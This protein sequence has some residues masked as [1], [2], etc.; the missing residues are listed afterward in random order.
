MV[1]ERV[2]AI[3]DGK[4]TPLPGQPVLSSAGSNWE[5]FLLE[6]H[7][8]AAG[9]DEVGWSWHDTHIGVC[10]AGPSVI[11]VAGGAGEGRFLV[12]PGCI[13]IFPSGCDHTNIHH[14]GGGFEFVVV[15]VAMS[16]LERLFHEDGPQMDRRLGPQ[17]Y[18][19]DPNLLALIQ[20]MRAEV[21]DG[22]PGGALYHESLCLALAAYAA[23]RYSVKLPMTRTRRPKLSPPQLRRVLEYID[24]HLDRRMTLAELADVVHVSPRHFCRLFRNTFG[25]T[26]HR[27]VVSLRVERARGLLAANR[28]PIGEIAKSLGFA[29]QS[30]FTDVFH[31]AT[32]TSPRY[33]RLYH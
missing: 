3:M 32:G 23:A 13:S 19:F 22:C 21:Q 24:A 2:T 15:Q 12:S 9:R 31:K 33:Y 20:T 17:L 5:G 16:R 30:H 14:S 4:T 27:Y 6:Q 7:V 25:A 1:T 28:L 26:P 10:V 8:V 11:S 18:V 29:S